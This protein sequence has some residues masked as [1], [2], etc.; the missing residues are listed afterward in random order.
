M[1]SKYLLFLTIEFLKNK[2]KNITLHEDLQRL[3]RRADTSDRDLYQITGPDQK[4][5]QIGTQ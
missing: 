2:K 1:N 3:K 5:S 4:Q